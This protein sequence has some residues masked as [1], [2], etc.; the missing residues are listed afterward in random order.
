MDSLDTN[1]FRNYISNIQVFGTIYYVNSYIDTAVLNV[2]SILTFRGKQ[3]QD[4]WQEEWYT[5]HIL[6]L[7]FYMFH[8]L[9][10]E[11]GIMMQKQAVA[12]YPSIQYY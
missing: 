12:Q 2:F 1:K 4:F 11:D 3:G 10:P 6:L 9:G 7:M 8:T 5:K